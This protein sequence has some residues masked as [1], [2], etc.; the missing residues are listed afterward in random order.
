MTV[1]I[2]RPIGGINGSQFYRSAV[3]RQ[4]TAGELLGL[5]R[6]SGDA[7]DITDSPVIGHIVAS[8]FYPG[9]Q[10]GSALGQ[11]RVSGKLVT[12]RLFWLTRI[13]LNLLLAVTVMLTGHIAY[14][15]LR[16][17]DS[18]PFTQ[19]I[20]LQLHNVQHELRDPWAA[21]P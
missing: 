5:L 12:V 19:F 11:G 1:V 20:Q 8:M 7:S 2:P 17:L 21:L 9:M 3:L 14:E 6:S 16:L 15:T 13:L 4:S 18:L 10:C